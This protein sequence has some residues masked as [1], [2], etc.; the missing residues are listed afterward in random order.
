M[1][2]DDKEQIGKAIA[3]V[4]IFLVGILAIPTSIFMGLI[5]FVWCTADKILILI[6]KK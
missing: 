5:S 1:I 6:Q 4:T 3:Y 2:N